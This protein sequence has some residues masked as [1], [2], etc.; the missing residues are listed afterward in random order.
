MELLIYNVMT[1]FNRQLNLHL[2][3]EEGNHVLF[4]LMVYHLENAHITQIISICS[5]KKEI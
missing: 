4:D 2:L 1:I 3:A 5:G